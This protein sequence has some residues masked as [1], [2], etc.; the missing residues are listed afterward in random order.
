MEKHVE[1][2]YRVRE[3]AQMLGFGY[4]TV[5]RWIKLGRIRVVRVGNQYRIPESEVKRLIEG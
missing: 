5:R 1:K 4:S 2:L 3:V